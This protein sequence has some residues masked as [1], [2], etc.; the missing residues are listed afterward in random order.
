MLHLAHCF[1]QGDNIID[2]VPSFIHNL[3]D[4]LAILS[5]IN[6]MTTVI[7]NKTN[8]AQFQLGKRSL[9]LWLFL[10]FPDTNFPYFRNISI[11]LYRFLSRRCQCIPYRCT[12]NGPYNIS[13]SRTAITASP[14]MI[15]ISD[16][17]SY[18][19]AQTSSDRSAC[20]DS[21]R[22][23][24]TPR[25]TP[26]QNQSGKQNYC[27]LFLHDLLYLVCYYLFYHFKTGKTQ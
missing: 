23:S 25:C 26:A 14:A 22:I 17:P 16:K 2:R 15:I 5:R 20:H 18:R 11:L 19:A 8:P 13:N 21:S 10:I 1:Y 27:Y 24:H 3:K 4:D 7:I 6:H 9:H 12:G